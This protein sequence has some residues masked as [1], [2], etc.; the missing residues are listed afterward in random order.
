MLGRAFRIA[1]LVF[2]AVW[3]NVILP[4]HTRGAVALPGTECSQCEPAQSM[5][6]C[7]PFEQSP[8]THSKPA[9]HR[10]PAA[11]CAICHFAARV[12]APP[13]VDFAPPPLVLVGRVIEPATPATPSLA[14]LPTYDGRAPPPEA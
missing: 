11:N 5:D 6:G 8:P 2:Q 4:G 9:N 1:L 13:V 14:L 7:C 3:L 10:D 12:T